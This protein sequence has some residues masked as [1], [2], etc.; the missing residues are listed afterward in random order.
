MKLC[1][2]LSTVSC[3]V[4]VFEVLSC[5]SALLPLHGG[6][7]S[8][9]SGTNWI[10]GLLGCAV[11]KTCVTAVVIAEISSGNSCAIRPCPG[12]SLLRSRGGC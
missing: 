12:V 3:T 1:T 8:S 5:S 4:L 6:G 11:C 7:C 10:G 9:G 2:T